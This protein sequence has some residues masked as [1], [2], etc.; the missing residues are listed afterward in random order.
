MKNFIFLLLLAQS[1]F[2]FAGQQSVVLSIPGMDCPVCPITIKKSL[3]K[4]AGVKSVDVSYESKTAAVVF[5]DQQTGIAN[6]L[7][8][9]ENAGYPSKLQDGKK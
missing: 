6:L 5:D 8:A 2:L 4:V 9:T 3:Q 1:G 7:K